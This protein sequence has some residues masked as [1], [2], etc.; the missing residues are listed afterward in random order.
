MHSWPK[1]QEG[2][3]DCEND[4]DMLKLCNSKQTVCRAAGWVLERRYL[5][6]PSWLLSFRQHCQC[7]DLEN[8]WEPAI[9]K[10][11]HY[12]ASFVS[13][14]NSFIL[15]YCIFLGGALKITAFLVL[16]PCPQFNISGRTTLLPRVEQWWKLPGAGDQLP[17]LFGYLFLFTAVVFFVLE[18]RLWFSLILK[19]QPLIFSK[20]ICIQSDGR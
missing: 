8:N 9:S 3:L 19:S 18:K 6:S 15:L 5:F 20:A 1:L 11:W 13:Q 12:A 10:H 4:Y 17:G 14:A 16:S 2:Y 7:V